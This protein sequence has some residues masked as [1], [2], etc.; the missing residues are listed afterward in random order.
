MG[1]KRPTFAGGCDTPFCWSMEPRPGICDWGGA[2]GIFGDRRPKFA[3][4]GPSVTSG[5]YSCSSEGRSGL[6]GTAGTMG[7]VLPE[8]TAVGVGGTGSAGIALA[9]EDLLLFRQSFF[10]LFT[11]IKVA[12]FA[13]FAAPAAGVGSESPLTESTEKRLV[14]EDRMR[15]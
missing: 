10:I 13:D 5:R 8:A 15:P 1:D 3:G 11:D 14:V 7:D 12:L 4:I 9:V 6:V 2:G